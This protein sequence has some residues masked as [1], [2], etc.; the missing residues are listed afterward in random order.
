MRA[1]LRSRTPSATARTDFHRARRTVKSTFVSGPTIECDGHSHLFF[2]ICTSES[3]WRVQT[4]PPSSNTHSSRALGLPHPPSSVLFM[5][6][7]EHINEEQWS[8]RS[9]LIFAFTWH[10]D[11]AVKPANRRQQCPLE[12]PQQHAICSSH[13]PPA[14]TKLT[15]HRH[16]SWSFRW[17]TAKYNHDAQFAKVLASVCEHTVTQTRNVTID[18]R[19]TLNSRTRLS[20]IRTFNFIGGTVT[21]ATTTP[22]I[23]RTFSRRSSDSLN[24]FSVAAT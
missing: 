23:T 8:I 22:F 11:C 12:Q 10:F 24:T 16:T 6:V 18:P 5:D 4:V 13:L 9:V 20:R 17:W 7:T 3:T 14:F 2:V 21:F 1:L 19:R 15:I